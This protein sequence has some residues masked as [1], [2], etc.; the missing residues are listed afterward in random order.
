MTINIKIPI[1]DDEELMK[2]WDY[3]KNEECGNDPSRIGHR[4]GKKVWWIC[5]CSH[6]YL[7]SPEK[8]S[9]NINSCP[10]CSG[11][12]IEKG[13][14]DFKTIYP[15][16][17]KEWNYK[18][19]GVTTPDMISKKSGTKYW[20]ICKYGHEWQATP[21]DRVDSKTGCPICSKIHHSS[22][23]EQAVLFYV[24]KIY[25]NAINRYTEIFNNGMELDIYIPSV[26]VGI[27]FDGANWHKTE[28]E[29]S[30]E[31]EKYNMCKE[32]GILLLRIKEKIDNEWNDVADHIWYI[33][34]KNKTEL[35]IVIKALLYSIDSRENMWYRKKMDSYP[36][37]IEV[38]LEKDEKAIRE[39]MLPTNNSLKDLRPDIAKEWNYEKN[40]NLLPEMFGINSNVKVW[41]KCSNCNHEWET[42]IIHRA[43][44]RSSG[45]PKCSVIK[46]KESFTKNY[47][48]KNGSL[49]DNNPELAKEWHPTLNGDLKPSDVTRA[50]PRKVWWKCSKCG[51]EWMASPNNR[52]KG[53]GCPECGRKRHT[54]K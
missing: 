23:P 16:I 2:I 34:K 39:Y 42:S 30:R 17:A 53:V 10:I 12:R 48:K 15:E 22:F 19:N 24:K 6:H 14:N 49:L 31:R 8:K 25:P 26:K 4:S 45:C 29:H 21:H 46:N 18:K 54:L 1:I 47:I 3:E 7:M 50:T 41:W 13:I 5:D 28:T 37:F 20:W 40:H 27:E 38:N 35:E 11:H 9:R 33:Q 36:R 43:G 32:K 52:S 44:K 51:F